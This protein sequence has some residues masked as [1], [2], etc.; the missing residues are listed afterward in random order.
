MPH[1]SKVA[2]EHLAF[3]AMDI[4]RAG[5]VARFCTWMTF[6]YA[7]IFGTAAAWI[8]SPRLAAV[9][10][11]TFAA[12][13]GYEVGRRL[14][15]KERLRSG[16]TVFCSSVIA[17]L[18]IITYILPE[19]STTYVVA[20]FI[21]F[22]F[23]LQYSHGSIPRI[24]VALAVLTGLNALVVRNLGYKSGFPPVLMA[25][26]DVAGG[27]IALLALS[28]L[29]LRIRDTFATRS[30]LMMRA[31][32]ESAQLRVDKEVAEREARIKSEFLASM[33]HEI[34]TPMN[35]II[36]M[37]SLISDTPLNSEQREFAG[38][39]RGSSEHLLN[40]INDILD[41]AKIEAGKMEIEHYPFSLRTAVEESLDMVAI[42]ADE[43]RLELGYTFSDNV[44]ESILS[45][46]GRLKQILVNL[47]SNAVKF[48]ERGEVMVAVDAERIDVEHHRIHFR[49]RDTGRGIT[50]DEAKRLFQPFGQ[51]DTSITRSHG[52]T[53][54]G[55]VICRRLAEAMSGTVAFESERH[56]GSTFHVTIEAE[57]AALPL[58]Q[59]LE[60]SGTLK[61]L[62]ALAVDD[63]ET[64][65]KILQNY[66]GKWG[67]RC[68]T[69]LRPKD[70][71]DRV[72]NSER[73]DVYLLDLRMPEM[74]GA[75]LAQ[76]LRAANAT[77]PMVL[78]SSTSFEKPA[79]GLFDRVL[80]KPIKPSRLHDTILGLFG[81][82]KT[83]ERP[84]P[85][86]AFDGELAAEKPLKVLVV[87]DNAINQMVI[88]TML[89]RFGYTSDFAGN[90][91]EAIE[92]VRRQHY[93]LVFMDV[94]MPEVDGLS[95]TR[96]IRR[97][98]DAAQTYVVGLT[99]NATVDDRRNCEAAGMD[100]YLTKPITAE[101]L[102][103]TLKTA[104]DFKARN[105]N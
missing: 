28:L 87:E 59:H 52:G 99:A 96:E 46:A 27:V 32:S 103:V 3:N 102:T 101:K 36:G 74:D 18:W 14:I 72:R 70:A 17:T 22:A 19:Q 50:P 23:A 24:F 45:D 8:S 25:W 11:A 68:V 35:A 88:Q 13:L 97:M 41:F 31:E 43:K 42:K 86:P 29:F 105:L 63:N 6:T 57:T 10:A 20:S 16:V 47:L 73:F 58:P 98:E 12:G 79:E 94:R 61:G 65:L 75:E 37:T 4:R 93:D 7:A 77:G 92:S 56:Q 33:S 76:A 39:L 2:G 5:A 104:W 83:G 80:T 38:I 100:G 21:P 49:V 54:L 71:L 9:A 44:P 85:V 84:A 66:L 95:A 62:T 1:R 91:R 48:T 51:A 34:R 81:P 55:L 15:V 64:N 82:E 26:L 90:G 67:M 53:G 69:E 78:L 89:T 60:D 30:L 40:I